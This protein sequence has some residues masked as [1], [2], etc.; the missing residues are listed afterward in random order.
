MHAPRPLLH[1]QVSYG[2]CSAWGVELD[3][4]KCDKA[5]AFGSKVL[6]IMEERGL[7]S[8]GL[9]KPPMLHCMPVEKVREKEAQKQSWHAQAGHMLLQAEHAVSLARVVICMMACTLA[10]MTTCLCVHLLRT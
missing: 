8:A 4:V 7:I 6:G 2:V 1:A 5:A 9:H 3:R 10:M